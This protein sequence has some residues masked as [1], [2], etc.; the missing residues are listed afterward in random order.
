MRQNPY[1]CEDFRGKSGFQ[2]PLTAGFSG[3]AEP[4]KQKGTPLEKGAL[5]GIFRILIGA[6]NRRAM[7][8]ARPR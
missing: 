7:D 2:R 4:E 5:A 3:I 8:Q 1:V 6:P